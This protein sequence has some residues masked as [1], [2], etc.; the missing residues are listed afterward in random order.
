M[1]DSTGKKPRHAV[2]DEEAVARFA[3]GMCAKLYENRHNEL[4][5]YK[6]HMFRHKKDVSL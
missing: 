5:F 4:K 1:T 6:D 3:K 2:E